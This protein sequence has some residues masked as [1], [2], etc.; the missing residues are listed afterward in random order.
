MFLAQLI[1]TGLDPD[2]LRFVFIVAFAG[3]AA[4]GLL[5]AKWL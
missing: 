2:M 3:V 1:D 5:G 4:L